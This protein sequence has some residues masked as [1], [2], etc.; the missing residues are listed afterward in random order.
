M[1]KTKP[2]KLFKLMFEGLI[3]ALFYGL[4]RNNIN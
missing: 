1:K 3:K 2:K 4:M